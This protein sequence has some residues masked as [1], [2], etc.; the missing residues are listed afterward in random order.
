MCVVCFNS[1]SVNETSNREVMELRTPTG[2][3]LK[4]QWNKQV[5]SQTSFFVLQFKTQKPE[6]VQKTEMT[7]VTSG[8]N[9]SLFS[10]MLV[11]KKIRRYF[12]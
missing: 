1:N 7:R 4:V 5:I 10:D 8:V 2:A 12:V 9:E 3:A 11:Q 6:F